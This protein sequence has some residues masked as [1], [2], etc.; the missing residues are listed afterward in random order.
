MQYLVQPTTN[1]DN[2]IAHHCNT[3]NVRPLNIKILLALLVVLVFITT[4]SAEGF[5]FRDFFGGNDAILFA[6]LR[7]FLA[8]QR[9]GY[10]ISDFEG[11]T[12]LFR[13]DS[14][15]TL[16]QAGSYEGASNIEEYVKFA[17]AGFSPY[18]ECC[19]NFIEREVKFVGYDNGQCEFL[20]VFDRNFQFIPNA[21]DGPSEPIRAVLAIK[22]YV[23]F[24]KQ[25]MSRL[26]V[27]FPDDFLRIFFA[28]FLNSTN[29]RQFV[30]GVANGVCA[31]TL[32]ITENLSNLTCEEQLLTLP[33]TDGEIYYIDGRSQGCRA[34]HA[35]FAATNPV[36]HCAH[37]SYAPLEDPKGNTKCQSSKG[38]L[39]S[40]LFTDNELQM[41][42]DFI[43]SVGLDPELGHNYVG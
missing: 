4:K 7:C 9:T 13:D 41:I 31:N 37:I 3:M 32:N 8:L 11:Y 40:S 24:E 27:F 1:T 2:I 10:N 5:L 33:A 25:Y 16:A 38:T 34:L 36:N 19:N 20:T 21:T 14:I 12:K 29:T 17:Y 28:V 6:R 18:L 26:N 15:V 43:V 35:V 23:D 39:P 30:C 42:Q 22:I